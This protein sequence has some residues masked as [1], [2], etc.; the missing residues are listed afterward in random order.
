[1][2][3]GLIRLMLGLVLATFA[4]LA[5][6]G[7][8]LPIEYLCAKG[9]QSLDGP[10]PA[11]AWVTASDGVLPQDAGRTCWVR[12]TAPAARDGQLTLTA[13]AATLEHITVRDEQGRVVAA[14]SDANGRAGLDLSLSDGGTAL[15]I[16]AHEVARSRLEVQLQRRANS[17]TFRAAAPG[18]TAA[19]SARTASR[20]TAI[21]TLFGLLTVLSLGLAAWGQDRGQAIL[22][23]YFAAASLWFLAGWTGLLLIWIDPL[24]ALRALVPLVSPLANAF[25]CAALVVI[26]RLPER[27]PRWEGPIWLMAGLNLVGIPFWFADS[28]WA[29]KWNGVIWLVY[30]P[31]ALGACWQVAR[32]GH[33]I[34]WLVAL[35]IIVNLL[36][37]GPT[38]FV[39]WAPFALPIEAVRPPGLLVSL[40]A[41]TLPLI[42]I[43]TMVARAREQTL[44]ARRIAAQEVQARADAE[45]QR[46]RAEAE[47]QARAAADAANQAKSEFLATMS[48]EIRTPMNGVIG[49]TGLLLDTPLNPDQR[50]Q[51]QTIRDSA[52]ALMTV[53]NDILDFSKI[54]AGKMSVEALPVR[55]RP[56]LNG[57]MD[58][59]RFRAAEKSV[60]LVLDAPAELPEAVLTDPTRL[61]QV[62]LN[63]LTNAVKFT[64]QGEVRLVV[65]RGGADR[66]VFEV[67]DTGIGL[68]P[69]A[70]GRLFQRYQQ[71]EAGTARQYGGTGL[72]LAISRTL[73]ELLG[74][75]LT[76]DSAGPGQGSSFRFEIHAPAC[77]APAAVAPVRLEAG[78]AARHPL[79]IL[80][81]EDNLVNQKLALRLLGQMGYAAD[82]AV[83][84]AR[85]VEAVMHRPYDVVLM[86]VQMP[87]MDGLAATRALV[88]ALGTARPRI[89]GMSANATVEDRAAGRDAGMDDY[90][91]K[92]VRVD[93]LVQALLRVPVR[94]EGA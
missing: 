63:L 11:G 48:H 67:R 16:L 78:M 90:V 6:A 91:S 82:L 66:L 65:R 51:A 14:G 81:A 77:E 24:P 41:L 32:Q 39:V 89:V 42:V 4:A 47:A 28:V 31:V 27:A 60:S 1:M 2:S 75:S 87:E 35:S 76:A 34:G 61:R 54:E 3:S 73:A 45:L 33:A 22:A 43:G 79:R 26:L 92:P 86:D 21:V 15:S 36:T 69:E 57:C 46:T 62:L 18:E 93:E 55:L 58:V 5:Q 52:E 59:V 13:R 7:S 25:S 19:E 85:A 70:L 20:L 64:P 94:T 44:T 53:I 9:L 74:G 8:P 10:A 68:T 88:A 29:L 50:E 30:L 83:D 49:M 56:L 17:V 71:A 40:D 23:G 84:G 38:V 37:W 80:L 72:G 12:V